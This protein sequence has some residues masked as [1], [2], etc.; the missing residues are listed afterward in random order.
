MD[1]NPS[2]EIDPRKY[3]LVIG[4]QFTA[5]ALKEVGVDSSSLALTI[6]QLLTLGL[7]VLLQTDELRSDA[8]RVKCD[9]LY[10]NAYELDPLFAVKKLSISLQKNGKYEEW[11]KRAFD[12]HIVPCNKS[13]SLQRIK[14]LQQEGA[15][16]MYTHYDDALSQ[17]TKTRPILMSDVPY[18]EKWCRGESNGILHLH[19]V[20]SDHE[21]V[22]FDTDAHHAP[23]HPLSAATAE[24]TN[25][26]CNRHVLMLGFDSENDNEDPILTKFAERYIA[27]FPHRLHTIHL[28]Q[29]RDR[30][31]SK[32]VQNISCM[33]APSS[34]LYPLSHTSMDICECMLLLKPVSS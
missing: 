4:P 22:V 26:F 23:N 12:F 5:T 32:C 31:D 21:T 33:E 11:L 3:L 25:V 14:Q 16:V 17:L 30:S 28:T 13:P 6:S 8:E 18:F 20:Y 2:L 7:E 10:R 34:C 19:G 9:T 15:L 27:Q 1:Y 29:A 24:L